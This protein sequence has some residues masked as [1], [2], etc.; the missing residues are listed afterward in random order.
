M[1]CTLC[2]NVPDERRK[3]WKEKSQRKLLKAFRKE[4]SRHVLVIEADMA[5]DDRRNVFSISN[6]L[7][8]AGNELIAIMRNSIEQLL[9]TKRYMESAGITAGER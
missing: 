1:S 8:L 3:P 5:E 2:H 4:S 9:R 6:R 7:R